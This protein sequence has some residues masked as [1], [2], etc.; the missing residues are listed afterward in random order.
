MSTAII[1]GASG[2]IGAAL[3]D[4]FAADPAWGAVHAV[5]RRPDAVHAGKATGKVV[6]HAADITKDDQ[7]ANLAAT[8]PAPEIVIVATG[9]L[10]DGD[11]L[12]PEKTLKQQQMDSFEQLF[13]I[14]TFGP[15]LVA[16]HLIP[17]LPRDRRTVFAALSARV[18]SIGD[19]RLGGWHAYRASKAALNMLLR[20]YAIEMTRWNPQSI[21]VG[22]HPG[23][24][25]TDLS[26]PFRG[27]VSSHT[28][29]E[30][31]QS[32]AHLKSVIDGLSPEE[33]GQ[34]FDWA[35]KSIPF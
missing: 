34:M 35:G 10:S 17:R 8:L 4:T 25:K 2:G 31:A 26:A 16:K 3:V 11:E 14:N 23:T 22:L 12:R 9:L 32:A 6:V 20:C 29:Q 5:A 7:L 27:N 18:G 19:N 13:R 15:A 33:T 1:F 30:P 28:L 24:V 21:C